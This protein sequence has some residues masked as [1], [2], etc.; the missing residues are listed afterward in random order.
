MLHRMF[1]RGVLVVLLCAAVVFAVTNRG[2]DARMAGPMKAKF[3]PVPIPNLQYCMASPRAAL[4]GPPRWAT[5]C[6]YLPSGDAENFARR[7]GCLRVRAGARVRFC[8]SDQTEGVWYSGSCGTLATSLILQW[9]GG[10]ECD[11]GTCDQCVQ[12]RC[13]CGQCTCEDGTCGYCLRNQCQ[14][15]AC[16]GEGGADGECLRN[17]CKC[18]ACTGKGNGNGEGGGEC[19]KNQCK[20]AACSG[21]GGPNADCVRNRCM[22]GACTCDDGTCGCCLQVRCQCG[23]CACEDGSCGCCMQ[24]RCQCG[25]CTCEGDDCPCD[26]TCPPDGTSDDVCP[27]VTIG[28]DGARAT[29][30]GPSI[31]RAHVGVAVRFCK[32]GVYYLRGIIRTYAQPHYP[33]PLEQWD[34]L[35][36]NNGTE[37][38]LPEIPWA[39]DRDIVYVRVCV[40]DWPTLDVEPPG[41]AAGGPDDEFCKPVPRQEGLGPRCEVELSGD[42]AIILECP[43]N[44]CDPGAGEPALLQYRAWNMNQSQTPDG[45]MIRDRDTISQTLRG[46]PRR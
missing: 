14:C 36:V 29:R 12:N 4:I 37:D 11:D 43:D 7:P 25:V 27:W 19:L 31:G 44:E 9:C 30:E 20:C 35:L 46:D 28:R 40:V 32:P 3:A 10:C 24:N 23:E 2:G 33:L 8:L 26:D 18:A 22:C 16:K 6:Y 15:A 17:Q 21:A 5:D 42:E 39:A 45:T 13:R 34:H 41:H 38:V 1:T